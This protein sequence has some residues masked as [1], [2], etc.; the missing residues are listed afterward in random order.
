MTLPGNAVHNA[1]S[2]RLRGLSA[3]RASRVL[4]LVIGAWTLQYS[5]AMAQTERDLI[6][7]DRVRPEM[8]PGVQVPRGYALVIGIT[9][10]QSLE[11]NDLKFPASDAQALYRV[12]ISKE[13][14]A[15]PAENVHLL[16]DG[17]A[18]LANIRKE[19]EEWLPAVAQPG[20]RVVV[21]FAG[22]GFV[23]NGRGYLAPWDVRLSGLE[24]SGYPMQTLGNVLANRV[25]ARWKAVFLDACH[26]GK[27][28]AETT[29]EQVSAQFDSAMAATQFLSFA[30]TL[31]REK[32]YEDPKLVTGFGVFTYYLI[33][34]LEGDADGD[35]CDGWVLAGELV[36]FVR[37]EVRKYVKDRG[38]TQTPHPG[39]DFDPAMVL[40]RS[41]KCGAHSPPVSTT[42][43]ALIE[44]NL[45]D[46]EVWIDDAYSGKL[47]RGKPL[48]IPSLSTGEH[49]VRG[50]KEGYECDVRRIVVAPAQEVG[51]TLRIRYQRS[52]KAAAYE[53]V[54]RGEKLLYTKR[55]TVNPLN[56]V[57]V[58]RSQSQSDLK[59][60]RGLF[61]RALRE[62]EQYAQAAYHLGVTNQ[63]LA[64]EAGSMSAFRRAIEIDPG[65]LQA[66]IHYA[67]VVIE[68]GDADKGIR[69]LT[70]ALRFDAGNDETHALLARAF[71][72][73]GVWDRC[74]D[75]ARKAI[76]INGTNATAHLW[77]ADCERQLAA[78][79]KSKPGFASA[80][81]G[82]RRFL[83]LTNYSTPVHE[84]V[85]YHFIGFHLGGKSHADRKG[86]YDQL[87]QSGFLGVC[88]CERNLGNAIRAQ[89]YC[90]RAIR[91]D[92][93]NPIG[94]F[95]LGLAQLGIFERTKSCNDIDSARDSFVKMLKL[96]SKLA[97]AGHA[98]HYIEEI[99][100]MRSLL[101]K[102]GC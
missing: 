63:L 44:V 35:P 1:S 31:G 15:F 64:D 76:A 75:S 28:N 49:T 96:N 71:F 29:N 30:A 37:S 99:D 91:H 67:G 8:R 82:Y 83:D 5:T 77:R 23:A 65:H 66:R 13:A 78:I 17:D 11:S 102:R 18:T 86:S 61:A 94:Y 90:R 33:K 39:S 52:P 45:D 84:W 9:H 21:F 81:E 80:A 25:K 3:V 68:N 32:S 88:I 16:L 95:L 50:C 73:K 54:Q 58:T 53:L 60:A 20:D 101:R 59:E 69:Q 98:K 10:Y 12:L 34:G 26:A 85:A 27:I 97:E 57:P 38:A 93:R 56:L 19:V 24:E 4:A 89:D 41:K 40:S 42:G 87:R 51:V 43:A 46:V 62:D 22:H 72:D 70:E 100:S 2:V 36:E 47:S 6:L 55:S 92:S 14:G 48:A 79:A 74:V 7:R